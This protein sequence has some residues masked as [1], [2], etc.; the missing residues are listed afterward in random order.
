MHTVSDIL[1]VKGN[2]IWAI[3]PETS[4]LSAL[5]FMA[6]KKVGALMVL[7]EGLIVG[8]ISERD[9]VNQVAAGRICDLSQ[10][11]SEYMTEKVIAVSPKHTIAQC[12]EIMT[13]RHIRHLPVLSDGQLVGIISIGDVV[14]SIISEQSS[15]IQ[16]LEE[17]IVGG[18]YGH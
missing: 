4:T 11:V 3:S 6:E 15:L 8:I 10:P 7:D 13:D 9:F 16:N 2:D 14:K 1:K 17:Y 5:R 18:G 12:M